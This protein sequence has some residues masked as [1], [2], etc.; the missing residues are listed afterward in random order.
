VAATF[1][2]ADT[3]P[4]WP[5]KIYAELKVL[6]YLRRLDLRLGLIVNFHVAVLKDGIYRVVSNLY[7]PDPPPEPL[8]SNPNLC[9]SAAFAF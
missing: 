7:P 6:S 3:S 1:S 2:N 9:V 4:S 5:R 8:T